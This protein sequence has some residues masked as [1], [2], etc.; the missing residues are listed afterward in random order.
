MSESSE[1]AKGPLDGVRILDLSAIVSGPLTATL[2]GDMGAKVTKVE[3]VDTGDIQRHVGSKR[4]GYSGFFHMLNRGKQSI[5]LDYGKPKG[6][7]I[8]HKLVSKADVVIQNFR[9]GVADRLGIGYQKLSA[10]NDQ[11]IYLSISGFGQSGPQANTRA[12]DPIIQIYSGIAGAQGLKRGEGPEQ[13]NQLIVDKLTAYTG[14]QA[15]LAALYSRSNTQK[16][17]HIE[18]SM[19]DTTAAFLWPD[20]G[21][22]MILQGD[23][24]E[25]IPPI[26]GS[27]QLTE[28]ADGWGA[29]MMLSDAE[30]QGLCR[31]YELT[32]LAMN[33]KFSTV[34]ARMTHHLEFVELFTKQVKEAASRLT[35]KEAEKRLLDN[36]VPF[37]KLRYLHELPDDPQLINNKLFREIDHPVAGRLRETRPAALFSETP[38]VAGGPAP[39]VG[40]HTRDIL[41]SIDMLDQLDSLLGDGA[42]SA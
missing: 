1:K 41:D 17:Q 30:F 9:P 29:T 22:D 27:G 14:S 19:L 7:E 37:A 11:I 31:S 18:L 38:A 25:H 26:G 42:V 10:I 21:A 3:R 35:I 32:D 23:N 34:A 5:A 36:H 4:N 8:V 39:G 40:Q 28:Y 6:I 20:A 13:V 24:I 33:E 16:G 15:I 2:L 12:Y